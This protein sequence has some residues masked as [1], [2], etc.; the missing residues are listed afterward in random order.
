MNESTQVDH[1]ACAA[2]HCPAL[3]SMSRGTNGE[4]PWYCPFHFAAD[5]QDRHHVTNELNRLRWLVGIVRALR[6]NAKLTDE[7][8]QSFVLAQRSDLAR[9]ESEARSTW[10]IR[11]E[12][13]L[14]Q[15]CK[16]TLVQP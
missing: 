8:K 13:V 6:A 9:K 12:G 14:A 16:D 11:L 15:S 5:P 1:S 7:M 10:M 2:T 3:A 4:S